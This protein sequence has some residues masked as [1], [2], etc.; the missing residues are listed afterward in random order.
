ML[1]SRFL[2]N[3]SH[4]LLHV[5]YLTELMQE[6]NENARNNSTRWFKTYLKSQTI[7]DTIA[8][9]RRRI[10]DLKLNFIVCTVLTD[11]WIAV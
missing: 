1:R 8:K 6:L 3:R 9:H 2:N 5:R 10:E 7:H 4:L 11:T